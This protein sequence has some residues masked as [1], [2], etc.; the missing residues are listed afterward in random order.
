MQFIKVKQELIKANNWLR[1]KI[2]EKKRKE[3]NNL[4]TKNN[5]ITK[6]QEE[7]VK[8]LFDEYEWLIINHIF[9][10]IKIAIQLYNKSVG[11]YENILWDVCGFVCHNNVLPLP[12]DNFNHNDILLIDKLLKIKQFS[13]IQEN[14]NYTLKGKNRLGEYDYK[15]KL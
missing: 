15:I 11:K 14:Y 10:I 7:K 8:Y 1:D 5:F 2:I 13:G 6:P 9:N 12:P 3:I 4:A